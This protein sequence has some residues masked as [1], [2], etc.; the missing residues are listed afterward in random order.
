MKKL[1]IVAVALFICGNN[2][3]QIY[4]PINP[5]EF[6]HNA[7][8]EDVKLAFH[9]PEKEGLS[10]NTNSTRVQFFYNK[11]DS[12]F[13]GWSQDRGYFP[14]GGLGGGGGGNIDSLTFGPTSITKWVG[15]VPTSYDLYHMY[16]Y[17]SINYDR[18]RTLYYNIDHNL[19]DSSDRADGVYGGQGIKIE[20]TLVNAVTIKAD[21]S[22]LS[23]DGFWLYTLH[24]NGVL[25]STEI[26]V[27]GGSS[28]G[29]GSSQWEDV[30]VGINYAGGNVGINKL[31][32]AQ[33]LDIDGSMNISSGNAYKYNGINLVQSIT[34]IQDYFFGNSG[35][36]T[37]TGTFNLAMG[38][39]SLLSTT[40]GSRNIAFGTAA[41]YS[42]TSGNDNVAIGHGAIGSI[43]AGVGYNKNT[44]IGNNSLSIMLGTENT[45]VG[46]NSATSLQGDL[47]T[48]MGAES[49]IHGFTLTG[50]YNSFF[51]GLINN[52]SAFSGDNNSVVGFSTTFNGSGNTILGQGLSLGTITN[53]IVIA[54]GAGNIRI[55]S[56]AAGKLKF[57][58]YG[59]G[60]NTG[61]ATYVLSVDA[62]GYV[63]ESPGVPFIVQ[64]EYLN[65]TLALAEGVLPGQVYNIPMAGGNA[66]LAVAKEATWDVV[67]YYS[68]D[69]IDN[70]QFTHLD[71]Q[72]VID[73]WVDWGDGTTDHITT[74]PA[75]FDHTYTVSGPGYKIVKMHGTL[76]GVTGKVSF[77][78][79]GSS[80]INDDKI[81]TTTGVHGVIG[82]VDVSYLF[83]DC[84]SL[85][86]IPLDMFSECPL[87]TKFDNAFHSC[88]ALT[89]PAPTLWLTY[90]TPSSALNC[91]GGSTGLTN[92]SSI[93]TGAP[94]YWR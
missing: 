2:F 75:S 35:N 53:N 33:K 78:D 92:Y 71:L 79:Y 19:I 55:R 26:E 16:A 88:A 29:G 90:P 85:Q 62:S 57:G 28:G 27:D 25:D 66:V 64:G 45:A 30:T 20:D 93:P 50:N 91:F 12:S 81:L 39:S 48:I 37:M 89:G 84:N 7:N 43:G 76:D 15:G 61:T 32:P 82:L 69:D 14:V 49:L 83:D 11:I 34:A 46:Y 60:T 31:V 3:A 6:G 54:D 77:T 94:Y 9:P 13:W 59:A 86:S 4:T 67:S 38:S 10:T 24:A 18:S 8:R 72:G 23:E 58:A 74:T 22:Y 87:L 68:Q 1:L 73:F 21:I 44:A 17:S 47:N 80:T 42:N 36:M 65:N 63:I 41:L 52:N 51:G 5:T 56:D 40:Y 70:V